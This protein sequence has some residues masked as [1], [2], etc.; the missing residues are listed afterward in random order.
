MA[1]PSAPAKS[2]YHHYIPRFILR[3][4]AHP[5][6]PAEIPSKGSANRGRRNRKN[7]YQPGEPMLHAI[8]LIGATAEHIETPVSRT[9]ALVDMY[10]DLEDAI[11]QHYLEEQLSRLEARA[12]QIIHKIR[13]AFEAGEREV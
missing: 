9:F 2:Q 4:F 10:R 12:G 8:N 11:N 3:N 7:G 13:K 5:F 1:P 6:K